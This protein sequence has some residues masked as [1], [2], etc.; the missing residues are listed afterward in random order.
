MPRDSKTIDYPDL[1]IKIPP[2]LKEKFLAYITDFVE[3][4]LYVEVD[5]KIKDGQLIINSTDLIALTAYIRPAELSELDLFRFRSA[6]NKQLEQQLL[7]SLSL[8]NQAHYKWCLTQL[9]NLEFGRNCE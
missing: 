8:N 1:V 4:H 5:P 3:N 6:A 7:K 2:V 9:K